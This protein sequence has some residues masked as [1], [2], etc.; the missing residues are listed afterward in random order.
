MEEAATPKRRK[1]AAPA[2]RRTGESSIPLDG[3]ASSSYCAVVLSHLVGGA[4]ISPPLEKV[5]PPWV[6]CRSPLLFFHTVF[7]LPP[8]LESC[9]FAPLPW[10]GGALSSCILWV[11]FFLPP[12]HFCVCGGGSG[13]GGRGDGGLFSLLLLWVL[14]LPPPP[15]WW[16][17]TPLPWWWCCGGRLCGAPSAPS[18]RRQ[19]EHR[20]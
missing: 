6:G 20:K 5:L 10:A 1:I 15:A 4:A 11:A 9:C 16:C 12:L 8:P 3:A 13:E 7:L 14:P 2:R 17:F 19:E 18:S